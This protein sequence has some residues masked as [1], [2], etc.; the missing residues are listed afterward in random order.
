VLDHHDR[1]DHHVFGHA[2][3]ASITFV[4]RLHDVTSVS[5]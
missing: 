3:R 5:E 1:S 4:L 2:P